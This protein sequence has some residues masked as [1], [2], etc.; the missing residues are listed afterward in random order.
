MDEGPLLK[1]WLCPALALY[2]PQPPEK[3]YV[4]AEPLA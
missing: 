1:G 3:L 4:S 2:F